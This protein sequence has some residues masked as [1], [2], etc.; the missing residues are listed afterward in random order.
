[1]PEE[2]DGVAADGGDLSQDHRV[3]VVFFRRAHD[4]AKSVGLTL[5]CGAGAGATQHRQWKVD[6]HAVIEGEAEFFH[7]HGHG[8][9]AKLLH[10][11]S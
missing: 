1:M 11:R 6:F 2:L 10:A 4:A 9:D 5:A 8:F 3:L 7:D